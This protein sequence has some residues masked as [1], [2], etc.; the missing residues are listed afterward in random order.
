MFVG[1]ILVKVDLKKKKCSILFHVCKCMT[2]SLGVHVCVYECVWQWRVTV[3][4]PEVYV[5]S[6]VMAVFFLL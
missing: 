3:H 5:S 2:E 1:G 4:S 6:F